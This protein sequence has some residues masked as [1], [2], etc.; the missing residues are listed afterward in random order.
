MNYIIIATKTKSERNFFLKLFK[1]MHKRIAM[2]SNPDLED[3][4]FNAAL[5]EA[6]QSSKTSLR[7][8]KS[9]LSKIALGK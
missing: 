9:H 5:K 6:E 7:K 1:K 3:Y 8:I 2:L 4:I